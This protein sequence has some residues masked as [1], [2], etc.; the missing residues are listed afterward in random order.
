MDF[1]VD[2]SLYLGESSGVDV[3]D[4]GARIRK[5][6]GPTTGILPNGWRVAV[7][8]DGV[9]YVG[10][11]AYDPNTETVSDCRVTAYAPGADGDVA[12]IR[13]INL[14]GIP[15]AMAINK[16]R[17]LR[18]PNNLIGLIGDMVVA[19]ERSTLAMATAG[20]RF[21]PSGVPVPI[22]PYPR[23]LAR[24]SLEARRDMLTAIAINEMASLVH[25][26]EA[27][28]ELE[29]TALNMIRGALYQLSPANG[30]RE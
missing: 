23:L 4:K 25:D 28:R 16:R 17:L 7:D 6:T 10:S 20:V 29:H 2:N 5:V 3:F 1:D 15:F 9:V 22:E 8:P 21:W 19:L 14:D 13:T 18:V 24:L 27:R 26:V 12:P 30:P 11:Y